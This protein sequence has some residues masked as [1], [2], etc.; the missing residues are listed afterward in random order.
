MARAWCW[1]WRP[2]PMSAIRNGPDTGVFGLGFVT[3]SLQVCSA[4]IVY[5]RAFLKTSSKLVQ[6]GGQAAR[7]KRRLTIDQLTWCC[8]THQGSCGDASRY[9]CLPSQ[10]KHWSIQSGQSPPLN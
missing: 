10:G 2:A 4:T 7:P 3:S 1:A 9:L 8:L 6:G 5:S